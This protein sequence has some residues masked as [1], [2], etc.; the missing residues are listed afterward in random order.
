[1]IVFITCMVRHPP[2]SLSLSLSFSL[3]LCIS[4]SLSVFSPVS[5]YFS[6]SLCY[7]S[8]SLY[9]SFRRF[10]QFYETRKKNVQSESQYHTIHEEKIIRKI[11]NDEK[12][13]NK[14][15]KYVL[16]VN[17]MWKLE[18]NYESRN[19]NVFKKEKR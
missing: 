11:E 19:W 17:H 8:L 5:L 3:A 16:G 2:T 13:E 10:F 9:I 14:R 12:N 15:R 7:I 18:I 4:L 1:M 6:L